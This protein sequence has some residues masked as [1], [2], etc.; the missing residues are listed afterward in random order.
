[1][2]EAPSKSPKRFAPADMNCI[3]CGELV[4][5]RLDRQELVWDP[6][7]QIFKLRCGHCIVIFDKNREGSK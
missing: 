4:H 5:P 6:Q 1:M 7:K 3:D 2:S